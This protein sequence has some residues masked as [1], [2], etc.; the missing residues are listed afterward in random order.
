M[1]KN[2]LV[3][4]VAAHADMSKADAGRAVDAVSLPLRGINFRRQVYCW[5]WFFLRSAPCRWHWS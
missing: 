3:S 1:N 5:I 2:D 4:A